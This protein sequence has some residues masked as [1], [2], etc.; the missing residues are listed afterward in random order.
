MEEKEVDKNS[1]RMDL[2]NKFIEE[3]VNS[4]NNGSIVTC[5]IPPLKQF[6]IE[7]NNRLQRLNIKEEYT[8]DTK[9]IDGGRNNSVRVR[10]FDEADR[11]PLSKFDKFYYTQ[12]YKRKKI[13]KYNDL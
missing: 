1:I 13:Y 2:Y 11:D 7:R 6:L 4:K 8:L 12:E 10:M 3:L 5:T 9:S